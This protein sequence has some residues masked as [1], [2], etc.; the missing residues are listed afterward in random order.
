MKLTVMTLAL[1]MVTACGVRGD[2][3]RDGD[4]PKPKNKPVEHVKE[5][6]PGQPDYNPGV[7]DY[8]DLKY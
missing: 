3:Y 4:T 7:M 6:Q 2:L 1:L 5:P 8:D